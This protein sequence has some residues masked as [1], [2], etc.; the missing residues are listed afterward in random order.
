MNTPRKRQELSS[1]F[2]FTFGM[3]PESSKGS[4]RL[5]ETPETKEYIFLGVV[6]I[7]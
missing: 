5:N 7:L 6:L 4:P 3:L 2:D 1:S